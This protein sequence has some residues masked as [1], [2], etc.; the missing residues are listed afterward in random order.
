MQPILFVIL[1]ALRQFPESVSLSAFQ[2]FTGDIF[3]D[4]KRVSAISSR[5]RLSVIAQLLTV[6]TVFFIFRGP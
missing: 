5:N 6:L 3:S 4:K 1:I 2:S